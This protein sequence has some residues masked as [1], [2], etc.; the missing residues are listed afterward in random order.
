[1]TSNPLSSETQQWC[2]TK[3]GKMEKRG[4][5]TLLFKIVYGKHIAVCAKREGVQVL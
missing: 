3:N 2:G 4:V 1:M 5:T